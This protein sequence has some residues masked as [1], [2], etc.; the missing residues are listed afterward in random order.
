MKKKSKHEFIKLAGEMSPETLLTYIESCIVNLENGVF[1][2]DEIP[3]DSDI[4]DTVL[5]ILEK[6]I[7]EESVAHSRELARLE[8]ILKIFPR[9]TQEIE[10]E[11]LH[12]TKLLEALSN[13]EKQGIK[14]SKSLTANFFQD[15]SILTIKAFLFAQYQN[16]QK[17]DTGNYAS[18]YKNFSTTIGSHFTNYIKTLLR[19]LE[20]K[21]SLDEKFMSLE[22]VDKKFIEKQMSKI[23]VTSKRVEDILENLNLLQNRVIEKLM[24]RRVNLR[25]QINIEVERLR[26]ELQRYKVFEETLKPQVLKKIELENRSKKNSLELNTKFGELQAKKQEIFN[27]ISSKLNVKKLSWKIFPKGKWHIDEIIKVFKEYKWNKKD[28]FDETRLRKIELTLKPT[29]CYVG[30][31]EFEGY[32]VFSFDWTE[33]VVLECPQKGNAVYIIN[34][35]WKEITKLSKLDTLSQFPKEVSRIIHNDTWLERLHEELRKK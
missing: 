29:I 11:L 33:K 22:D 4:Y 3:F 23:V 20:H 14:I 7:S 12:K 21:T 9:S 8:E 26:Q 25:S 2:F 35:D 19:R 30:E 34:G 17:D 13:I 24:Q 15:K 6:K 31:A 27:G 32:I 16:K 18:Q 28:K 10:N 5:R 1:L